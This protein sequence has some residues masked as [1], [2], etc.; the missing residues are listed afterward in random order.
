MYGEKVDFWDSLNQLLQK[1][2]ACQCIIGGDF[3]ITLSTKEKRGGCN[4]WDPFHE[5]MEDTMTTY[6]LLDVHL[7]SDPFTWLNMKV[8]KNHITMRL[9]RFLVSNNFLFVELK[10]K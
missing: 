3:N 1:G 2:H 9:D 4:V 8:G 7:V 6:D 5:H 10:V